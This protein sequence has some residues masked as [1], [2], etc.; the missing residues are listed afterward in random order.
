MASAEESGSCLHDEVVRVLSRSAKETTKRWFEHT[1]GNCGRWRG[2]D[3]GSSR[4]AVMEAC[5]R[6]DEAEGV[7]DEQ[8]ESTKRWAST[9]YHAAFHL[10][11]SEFCDDKLAGMIIFEVRNEPRTKT[12]G[13]SFA[14]PKQR[15]CLSETNERHFLP[16]RLVP[17]TLVQGDGVFPMYLIADL[18]SH[19]LFPSPQELV[20][21]DPHASSTLFPAA[22]DADDDAD[23]RGRSNLEKDVASEDER[24]ERDTAHGSG[25]RDKTQMEEFFAFPVIDQCLSLFKAN[26]A[27]RVDDWSTSDWLSSKV[28]GPYVLNH[29][30]PDLAAR[31]LLKTVTDASSPP[32]ARRAAMVAFVNVLEDDDEVIEKNKKTSTLGTSTTQPTHP[33]GGDSLFGDGFLMHLANVCASV[34][35][36]GVIGVEHDQVQVGFQGREGGDA[37][38]ARRD[39]KT[40][41]KGSEKSQKSPTN[42]ACDDVNPNPERI[43]SIDSVQRNDTGETSDPTKDPEAWVRIGA[44]WM[45]SLCALA[46]EKNAHKTQKKYK[47]DMGK[48]SEGLGD[49]STATTTYSPEGTSKQLIHT[50]KGKRTTR[51]KRKRSPAA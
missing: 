25:S 31:F 21:P 22:S 41:T 16:T 6:R 40:K 1:V 36:V 42:K 9:K 26:D 46:L 44:R 39:T 29:P 2:N 50:P 49:R 28:L 38:G 35:G 30:R 5:S 37:S 51:G 45:V 13:S 15:R 19:T 34:L 23:K 8:H 11:R 43:N 47:A 12:V 33:S 7:G 10:M 3:A 27:S 24:R 18:P 4:D 48:Q 20:L 14:T 17:A 32:F